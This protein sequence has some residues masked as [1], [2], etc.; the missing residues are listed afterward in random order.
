MFE[1][2][3][4][5]EIAGAHWLDLPYESK[6]SKLHGH[7]WI[8]RVTCRSMELNNQGMVIDFAEIKRVVM[9][10]DHADLNEVLDGINPTA[11]NIAR[12]I[13]HS[14]PKCVRVE[15]QESDGNRAIYDS[16]DQCIS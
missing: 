6:C 1:V 16:E 4:T 5:I 13:L 11:E 8:I 10:L 2:T 12:W 9:E 7:N 14:I 3:K 15:V